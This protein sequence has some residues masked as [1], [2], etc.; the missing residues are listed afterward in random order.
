M[1]FAEAGA[2]GVVLADLNDV[3]AVIEES[4]KFARNEKFRAIAVQVDVSDDDAVR[5]M[6]ETAV[7]EFGRI[8]YCVHSA[9]VSCFH[10]LLII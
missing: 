5:A 6:I 4:K 7:K 8:D 9:G 3:N 10:T 1:A 2:D